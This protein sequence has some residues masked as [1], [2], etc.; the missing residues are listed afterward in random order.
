MMRRAWL[1]GVLATVAACGEVAAPA[2]DGGDPADAPPAGPDAMVAPVTVAVFDDGGLPVAGRAVVGYDAGG[3][4][5][6]EV[7]TGAGGTASVV[8][9]AGG[10][11]V[12]VQVTTELGAQEGD[13]VAFLGVNP[14]DALRVGAPLVTTPTRSFTVSAPTYAG[15]TSYALSMSCGAGASNATPSFTFTDASCDGAVHAYVRALGG[16]TTAVLYDGD[17]VV[18]PGAAITLDGAYQPVVASSITVTQL[19][20]TSTT[21]LM[22]SGTSTSAFTVVQ[23]SL[24]GF[25]SVAGDRSA[26]A[27]GPLASVAGASRYTAFAVNVGSANHFGFTRDAA[28][29]TLVKSATSVLLDTLSLPTFDPAAR[30]LTW[31]EAGPRLPTTSYI[32]LEGDRLDGNHWTWTALAPYGGPSLTL[33]ALPASLAAVAME[34]TDSATVVGAYFL[35]PDPSAL[36][37]LRTSYPFTSNDTRILPGLGATSTLVQVGF[38]L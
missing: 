38:G 18:G 20:G 30:T 19:P 25:I 10:A 26:A 16:A 34:P 8:V 31:T 35:R 3:S 29:A 14:G 28:I 33:P 23:P 12:V 2:I 6:A 32:T 37:Q 9:P 24:G 5:L 22:A 36:D 21:A 27:S 1:T 13:V 4:V 11:V 15:A 7:T 17:V